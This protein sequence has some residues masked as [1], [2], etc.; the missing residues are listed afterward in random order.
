[1]ESPKSN[2]ACIVT[3]KVTQN[4]VVSHTIE[5]VNIDLL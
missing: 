4:K 2:K 5:K 3:Q 1:M